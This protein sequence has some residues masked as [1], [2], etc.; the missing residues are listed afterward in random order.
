LIA[1]AR[2]DQAETLIKS[3]FIIPLARLKMYF[4]KAQI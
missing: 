1:V 4:K 2:P 3:V